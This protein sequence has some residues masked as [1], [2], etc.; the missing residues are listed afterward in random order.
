MFHFAVVSLGFFVMIG[1]VTV[2]SVPG[3]LGGLVLLVWGLGYFLA[4][5]GEGF[6]DS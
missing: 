3:M 1:G 5:P 2:S 6:G 4:N